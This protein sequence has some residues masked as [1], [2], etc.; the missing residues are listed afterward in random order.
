MCGSTTFL[1]CISWPRLLPGPDDSGRDGNRWLGLWQKFSASFICSIFLY[2][3]VRKLLI[4]KVYSCPR[5]ADNLFQS[6]WALGLPVHS[7]A[8]CLPA[9]LAITSSSSDMRII[10]RPTHLRLIPRE[11]EVGNMPFKLP[12]RHFGGL[13]SNP[14][15]T[16]G[17]EAAYIT[18]SHL[19][20]SWGNT[21]RCTGR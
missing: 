2:N 21:P 15:A 7:M 5:I 20:I 9:V 18:Y 1:A 6:P 16:T 3:P 13:T 19:R 10:F 14:T 4:S 11:F 12:Q 17:W 8:K